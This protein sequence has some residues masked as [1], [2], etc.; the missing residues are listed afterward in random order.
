MKLFLK[1]KS[2]TK[3]APPVIPVLTKGFM[4]TQDKPTQGEEARGQAKA[5]VFTVYHIALPHQE[6][7]WQEWQVEIEQFLPK[8][9]ILFLEFTTVLENAERERIER[10]F[11]AV[12]QGLESPYCHSVGFLNPT[13][14][15]ATVEAFI[16][17]TR[18]RIF[19]ERV[20]E[21]AAGRYEQHTKA[22]RASADLFFTRR[23]AEAGEKYREAME[24][25]LKEIEIRDT[26]ISRQLET[27]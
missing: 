17:Q 20:P 7:I 2:V 6:K 4:K 25:Q 15:W 24:Q 23:Y 26:E 27:L 3:E 16:Q 8:V 1:K 19:L 12:A 21:L 18:K 14:S 22:L 11:N 5:Q 13:L 9:G 10:H